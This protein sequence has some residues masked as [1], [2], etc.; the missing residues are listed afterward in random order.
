[1]GSLSAGYNKLFFVQRKVG[2]MAQLGNAEKI[3]TC[4]WPTVAFPSISMCW[5]SESKEWGIPGRCFYRLQNHKLV[6]RMFP[7]G[8]IRTLY[9]LT[10][11]TSFENAANLS[12]F[13]FFTHILFLSRTNEFKT[14]SMTSLFKAA[15]ASPPQWPSNSL[16][17][18]SL[19]MWYRLSLTFLGFYLLHFPSPHLLRAWGWSFQT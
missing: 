4:V 3:S 15:Q 12:F 1:M 9:C 16:G 18:H 17:P 6:W 14:L 2:P 13:S 8:R 11:L 5:R 10:Y 7:E 19:A